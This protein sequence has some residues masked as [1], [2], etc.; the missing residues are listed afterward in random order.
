ML[1]VYQ[2]LH[3]HFNVFSL[4]SLRNEFLTLDFP[5]CEKKNT[6]SC[7]FYSEDREKEGL[8]FLKIAERLLLARGV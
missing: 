6:I 8:M 2:Q 1:R 5:L 3:S 7:F 4:K